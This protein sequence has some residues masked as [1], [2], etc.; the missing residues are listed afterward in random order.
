[1]LN[2]REITDQSMTEVT[3]RTINFETHDRTR[4]SEG[5]EKKK[6]KNC[7]IEKKEKKQKFKKRKD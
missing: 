4:K 5:V 7:N 6:K 2:D 3:K 1:M